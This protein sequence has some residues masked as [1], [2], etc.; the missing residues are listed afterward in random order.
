MLPYLQRNCNDS[1][2]PFSPRHHHHHVVHSGHD[3]YRLPQRQVHLH[4]LYRCGSWCCHHSHLQPVPT[5]SS[6]PLLS[7]DHRQSAYGWR[8]VASVHLLSLLGVER[9]HVL[10]SCRRIVDRDMTH[11]LTLR[12]FVLD[13][14][15]HYPRDLHQRNH[16][17][18]QLHNQALWK[19]KNTN[20]TQL[21]SWKNSISKHCFFFSFN[22]WINCLT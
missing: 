1:R 21:H 12:L 2:E 18:Y 7:A 9:R 16:C 10:H 11:D 13:P 3:H 5:L 6:L 4:P 8:S 17:D 14:V 22:A 20:A 19:K 15:H